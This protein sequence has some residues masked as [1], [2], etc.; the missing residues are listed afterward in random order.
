[1]VTRFPFIKLLCLFILASYPVRADTPLIP[2]NFS[3]HYDFALSGIRFGKLNITLTQDVGQYNTTADIATTGIVSIFVDHTSH[4][5]SS[6]TGADFA[7][8]NVN[9]ESSYSTRK[10]PKYVKMEMQGGVFTSEKLEPADAERPKVTAEQKKGAVDPL[11]FGV[12][13]RTAFASALAQQ[14]KT[15]AINYYDGR[16]LTRVDFT[17]GQNKNLRL[18]GVVYPVYTVVARRTLVAG[19][20]QKELSRADPNEPSLTIYFT[21]DAKFLPIRLEVPMLF[22]TASATLKM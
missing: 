19:F 2:I 11:A 1:M 20:T 15:F 16:R 14:Q 17:V 7:Y 18:S 12:A 5:T 21:H 13:L 4:T 6:G 8:P 9:Y 10:K 3:G 22:G